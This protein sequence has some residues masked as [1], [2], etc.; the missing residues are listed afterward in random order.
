MCALLVVTK[1]PHP[2]GTVA[3]HPVRYTLSAKWHK[4]AHQSSF[5]VTSAAAD[6]LLSSRAVAPQG[7]GVQQQLAALGGDHVGFS[8]KQVPG[9]AISIVGG[10]PFSKVGS[11]A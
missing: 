2:D 4:T 1:P 7:D 11:C 10:R 6:M 8:H 5:L 9:K 3:L